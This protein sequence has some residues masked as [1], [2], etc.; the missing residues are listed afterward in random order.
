MNKVEF[1]TFDN[2]WAE[3]ALPRMNYFIDE[4]LESNPEYGTVRMMFKILLIAVVYIV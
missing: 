2:W 1:Q 4:Y 3:V